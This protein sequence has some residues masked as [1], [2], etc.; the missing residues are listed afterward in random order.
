MLLLPTDQP[1]RF[2]ALGPEVYRYVAEC[3]ND[4]TPE[5]IHRGTAMMALYHDMSVKLEL[6]G[7]TA[8]LDYYGPKLRH[9]NQRLICLLKKSPANRGKQVTGRETKR[10]H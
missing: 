1:A 8:M 10:H 9:T 6:I 4:P 2:R 7:G 3:R 5:C